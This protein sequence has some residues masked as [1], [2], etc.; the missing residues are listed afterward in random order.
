M[1]K[2]RA[3]KVDFR[4]DPGLRRDDTVLGESPEN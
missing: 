3:F 1:G 2:L 4:M